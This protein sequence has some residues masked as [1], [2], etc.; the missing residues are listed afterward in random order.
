MGKTIKREVYYFDEPGEGNTDSVIE[1]VSQQMEVGDIKTVIIAS[2]SGETA[3]KFARK[4]KS[5]AYLVCVSEAPYRR[6]WGEEWPCLKKE[7]RQELERPG[8]FII[9]K[10]PYVF[11]DSVLEA[12]RWTSVL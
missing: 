8:F 12:A 2:T 11:H 1:A 3:I 4:F 9:D 7:F 6:E 10:A 5:K